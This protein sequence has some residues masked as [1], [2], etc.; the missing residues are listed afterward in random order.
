MNEM[1]KLWDNTVNWNVSH[2]KVTFMKVSKAHSA[3][4]L[5]KFYLV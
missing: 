5:H 4:S 2:L 1:G 3:G